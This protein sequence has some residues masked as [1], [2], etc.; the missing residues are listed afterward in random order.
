MLRAGGATG[1]GTVVGGVVVVVVV[2]GVVGVSGGGPTMVGVVAVGTVVLGV[3]V[4]V[5]VLVVLVVVVVVLVVVVVVA[6]TVVVVVVVLSAA[7]WALAAGASD[8]VSV[9]VRAAVREAPMAARR[10][11]RHERRWRPGIG[12]SSRREGVDMSVRRCIGT[13]AS[14]VEHE[15]AVLSGGV[16]KLSGRV[17][18]RSAVRAIGTATVGRR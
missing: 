1:P 16:G 8:T 17:L 15:L 6:G 11:P 9:A 14:R 10:A 7:G 3:V 13:R 4:V 18:R 2:G 5:V 12:W